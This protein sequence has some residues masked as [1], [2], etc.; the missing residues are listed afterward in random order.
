MKLESAG[1]ATDDIGL[2]WMFTLVAAWFG[3]KKYW[4]EPRLWLW[5]LGAVKPSRHPR[6][7][8]WGASWL[9]I[10][11]EVLVESRELRLDL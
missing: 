6:Q 1:V 9:A 7:V 8:H 4:H 2:E 10:V 3:S 11:S 5:L